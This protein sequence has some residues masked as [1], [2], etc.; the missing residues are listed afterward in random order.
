MFVT[1]LE[2]VSTCCTTD[3]IKPE[4]LTEYIVELNFSFPW[5]YMNKFTSIGQNIN[6]CLFT[7]SK[8][9]FNQFHYFA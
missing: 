7:F 1:G 3:Y 8:Y 6:I 4:C 2:R 9:F 5:C